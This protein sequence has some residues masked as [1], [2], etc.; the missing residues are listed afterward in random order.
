MYNAHLKSNR[1][2][3]TER[4]PSSTCTKRFHVH[5]IAI[6]A[7]KRHR[8]RPHR[9][10]SLNKIKHAALMFALTFSLYLY[11]VFFVY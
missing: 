9:H 2:R 5:S 10:G 4:P 11:Q 3:Y 8:L 1:A 6:K 7:C